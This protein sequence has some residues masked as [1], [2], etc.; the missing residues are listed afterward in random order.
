[1]YKAINLANQTQDKSLIKTLGPYA[2]LLT[3]AI[4]QPPTSNVSAQEEVLKNQKSEELNDKGKR[5]LLEIAYELE[6]RPDATIKVFED[7]DPHELAV[8]FCEE[9]EQ[10]KDDD[11]E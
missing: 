8:K 10:H 4:D 2:C 6:Y 9:N 1:M 3:K 11:I 7:D 5:L